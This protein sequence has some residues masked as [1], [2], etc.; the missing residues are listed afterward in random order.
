MRRLGGGQTMDMGIFTRR[1]ATQSHAA[2]RYAGQGTQAKDLRTPQLTL[3][4]V[5]GIIGSGLFLAS[6]QAIHDA[7]PGLVIAYLI[8]ATAMAIE[9]TALAEM[10]AADPRQG[11]FLVYSRRALGPGFTFVGGWIFWFSSV[12][13]LAAEATAAATFA[14]LWLPH[15]PTWILSSAFALTI[16]GINFLTVKGFGEVESGMSVV[17]LLAIALFILVAASALF[18]A[19][20]LPLGHGLMSWSGH[21]GFLPHGLK[22]VGAAMIVVMFSMSGTG[23]LGLAAADVRRPERTIGRAVRYATTAVYLLYIGSVLVITAVVGWQAVPLT[24]KS[25]FLTALHHFGMPWA[26]DVFN[27]VIL[28]AVLSAMN[29]GMF[30]TDR[31]LAGLARAG[32]APHALERMPRGIPRAANAVTGALLLIVTLLTY[33]LPKT[34]FIYLVTAT[35]F[36]SIFVW[37]LIVAT[38]IYYRPWLEQHRPHHLRLKLAFHP[39]LGRFELVLLLAIVA[40]A[41]LAPRQMLPLGIGVGA[42]AIFA[43]AYLVFRGMHPAAS[44]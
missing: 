28:L 9:M 41:P 15:L 2:R 20:P 13:N 6:G 26:V 16:S 8:G 10:S 36:Q 38:Q 25:P 22:G 24:G 44:R 1:F 17:K 11:S 32:D 19:W 33:F 39:W 37:M 31:V 3:M 35:G 12:L 4:T 42:T 27:V 43:A 5:G 21:G 30:A 7:G 34:A 18:L 23:V 40:T 29:A 14:T